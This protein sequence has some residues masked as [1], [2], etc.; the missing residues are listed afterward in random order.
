MLAL[1]L[2]ISTTSMVRFIRREGSALSDGV[3]ILLV[4][5]MIAFLGGGTVVR[6]GPGGIDCPVSMCVRHEVDGQ[7]YERR[8]TVK[9]EKRAHHG[10][11]RAHRPAKDRQGRHTR[12]QLGARVAYL[13]SDPSKT[14]LA[15]NTGLMNE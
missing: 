3:M 10:R 1:T 14:T 11:P 2:S 13:P 5:G 12:G 9:L 8:E 15:D 4:F 6:F 7:A